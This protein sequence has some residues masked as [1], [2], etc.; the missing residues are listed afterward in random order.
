MEKYTMVDQETCIACGT[1]GVTAPDLFDYD[2]DGIA[3]AILDDNEGVTAVTEDLIDDLEDAFESCPTESI[4]VADQPF[5][6]G[7]SAAS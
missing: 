4:K 5:S 3:F 2:D 6:C 7:K 1:C